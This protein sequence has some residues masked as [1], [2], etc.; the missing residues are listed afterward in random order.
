MNQV[1]KDSVY[2][3]GTDKQVDFMANV[4]GMNEEEH[5][6]FKLLH[7]KKSDTYIQ[8]ELGLS[9]KSYDRIVESVRAKLLLAVFYCINYAMD[10]I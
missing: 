1:L 3:M 9:R 10:D 2:G 7:R 5:A 6:V 8:Y 4:G